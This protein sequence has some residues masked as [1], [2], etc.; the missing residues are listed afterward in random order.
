M[1][2]FFFSSSPFQPLYSACY[3]F[4][5]GVFSN[6][7]ARVFPSLCSITRKYRGAPLHELKPTVCLQVCVYVCVWVCVGHNEP[8]R[9]IHNLHSF[10]M[11]KEGTKIVTAVSVRTSHPQKKKGLRFAFLLYVEGGFF[12]IWIPPSGGVENFC[13]LSLV[14]GECFCCCWAL[15]FYEACL[16]HCGETSRGIEGGARWCWGDLKCKQATR[17]RALSLH[18]LVRPWGCEILFRDTFSARWWC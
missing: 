12:F 18:R 4:R 14:L 16:L 3:P 2:L 5:M 8:C 6:S 9:R 17:K 13:F 7:S 11:E 1:D 15:F 10:M